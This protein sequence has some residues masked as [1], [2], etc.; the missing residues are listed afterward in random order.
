VL[1]IE[2]KDGVTPASAGIPAL[3]ASTEASTRSSRS[4][5]MW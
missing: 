1:V 3:G 2:D 5:P 4:T